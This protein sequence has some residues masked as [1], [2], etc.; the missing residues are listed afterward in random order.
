MHCVYVLYSAS[1]GHLY[2]GETANLIARFRSHNELS[3]KGYTSKFRPWQVIW[4]EFYDSRLEALKREQAL[5]SGQGRAWIRS[6]ILL[7][8][9]Q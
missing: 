8:Y 3:K 9:P 7:S 2:I 4:V 5:K 6:E 1:S